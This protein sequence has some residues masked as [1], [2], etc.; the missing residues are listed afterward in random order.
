I[1][2]LK[3]KLSKVTS[4]SGGRAEVG[5]W[6]ML[7]LIVWGLSSFWLY[8]HLCP[9]FGSFVRC[10]NICM[11]SHSKVDGSDA[12]A[13]VCV[14]LLTEGDVSSTASHFLTVKLFNVE[15]SHKV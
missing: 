4:K 8:D 12:D 7:Q 13:P 2:D 9:Q 14:R 15:M 10:M 11:E 6:E 3:R 5:T 1:T